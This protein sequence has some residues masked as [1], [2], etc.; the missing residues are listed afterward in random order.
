MLLSATFKFFSVFW[1]Y[2][3]QHQCHNLH[4]QSRSHDKELGLDCQLLILSVIQNHAPLHWSATLTHQL[5]TSLKDQQSRLCHKCG[6][7]ESFV[8]IAAFASISQKLAFSVCRCQI[9]EKHHSIFVNPTYIKYARWLSIVLH[10]LKLKISF[11]TL[12]KLLKNL[13]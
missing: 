4:F 5:E 9:I 10:N 1:F 12:H 3:L 8:N 6:H 11:T 13:L 7:C 2:M